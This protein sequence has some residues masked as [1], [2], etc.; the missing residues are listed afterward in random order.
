MSAEQYSTRES[1]GQPA[2]PAPPCA[3]AY[4]RAIVG[5]RLAACWRDPPLIQVMTGPRQVGK[6]TAAQQLI[7]TRGR[8]ARTGADLP[9]PPGPKWIETHGRV[10]ERIS[11]AHD[12]RSLR[13]L[14]EIQTVHGWSE[15]VK[16]LWDEQ[17]C[18][19][20]QVLPILLGSSALWVQP[21]LTESLSGRFRPHRCPHGSWPECRSA[22]GW[23]L[24]TWRYFGGYPGAA[25]L[26]NDEAL[27][28][29]HV[30]G[31]LIETV[32]AREVLAL[33]RITRPALLRQLLALAA[34][35]PAQILPYNP[36]RGPLQ[37]AGNTTTLAAY[38]RV[39]GI[40]RPATGLGLLSR[41]TTRQR[42]SSPKFVL[43]KNALVNALSLSAQ[44]EA[45]RRRCPVGTARRERG[46]R[47]RVEWPARAGLERDLLARGR[48]R[49]RLHP[50]RAAG[51]SAP[52]RSRAAD[53]ARSAGSM[54]SANGIAAQR[55]SSWAAA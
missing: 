38:L 6:T 24:T 48:S 45:P 14:D 35:Y 9:L 2:H 42:A 33:Q 10:A 1:M 25:A 7:E 53:T 23:G 20:G 54:L 28:K 29:R 13:I 26:T 4:A 49:S 46:R 3:R 5:E 43:W 22:F 12:Q 55:V 52:L 34:A 21:G 16:R 47:P 31:S 41:G 8:P 37:D 18:T 51:A 50:H 30:A 36:M 19:G 40:A 17:R 32:P 39:L 15:V 44:S 11:P 27:W